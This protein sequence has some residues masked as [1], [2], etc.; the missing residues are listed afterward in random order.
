MTTS[1]IEKN[2][3]LTEEMENLKTMG[4]DGEMQM[5]R[6]IVATKTDE[7]ENLKR[8]LEVALNPVSL[9]ERLT[10]KKKEIPK[11]VYCDMCGEFD[12]HAT[13]ECPLQVSS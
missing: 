13:T 7:V 5:L 12:L 10:P 2:L 3:R 9:A 8:Q 11:R 1:L 4:S 6:K